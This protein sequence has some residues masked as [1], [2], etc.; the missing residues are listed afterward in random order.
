MDCPI[1]QP[2]TTKGRFVRAT[3]CEKGRRMRKK[4]M[5]GE[6]E[7]EWQGRKEGERKKRNNKYN[8]FFKNSFQLIR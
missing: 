1:L 8:T 7:R 5:T 2:H 3:I 6:K 4:E